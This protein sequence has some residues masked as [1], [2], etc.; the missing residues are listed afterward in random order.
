[1]V[2]HCAIWAAVAL[3]MAFVFAPAISAAE[4][5]SN[6]MQFARG[7]QTSGAACVLA[8]RARVGGTVPPGT[9]RR[10]CAYTGPV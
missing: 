5:P 3:A 7:Q 9:C 6:W 4:N 2:R 10:K 1:M 8:C